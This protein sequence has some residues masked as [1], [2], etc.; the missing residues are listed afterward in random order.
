MF[1]IWAGVGLIAAGTLIFATHRHCGHHLAL[2]CAFR[3]LSATEDQK[4]QLTALVDEVKS[5]LSGPKERIRSL[6]QQVIDTWSAP[7]LDAG[8]M[9][10]LEA[11]LFEAIGEGSQVFRDAMARTHQILDP[12]QRQKVA[13]W[14]KRHHRHHAGC[15]GSACHCC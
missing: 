9:E 11:Q 7:T 1:G 6:R 5:R 2:K 10:A 15:H 14:V 8:R 12:G 13:E 4:Q 3:R